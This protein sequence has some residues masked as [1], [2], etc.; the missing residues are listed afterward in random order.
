MT[1]NGSVKLAGDLLRLD[2]TGLATAPLMRVPLLLHYPAF[3]LEPATSIAVSQNRIYIGTQDSAYVDAYALDGQPMGAIPVGVESR[4]A[5]QEHFMRAVDAIVY[6][7]PRAD[8]H[9]DVRR[10]ILA[11]VTKPEMLPAYGALLSDAEDMLWIQT[12][13]PGDPYTTLRGIGDADTRFVDISLPRAVTVL[14]IGADYVLTTYEAA[15]GEP[16]VAMYGLHRTAQSGE[17]AT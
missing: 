8:L 1:V 4:P 16:C 2:A 17:N 9:E 11:T 5:S 15:S 3:P 6:S 7:V 14:E 10:Q 12:S 13:F